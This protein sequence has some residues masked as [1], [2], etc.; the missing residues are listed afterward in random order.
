MLKK[1]LFPIFLLSLFTSVSAEETSDLMELSLDDLLN[2][3]V[4]TV[5]KSA[6]KLSDAPGVISVVSRDE[7]ERFGGLTLGD[8]LDR[9]PSLSMT[10]AYFTDRSPVASRGDLTRVTSGHVLLLINGRPV[11]ELQEGGISADV[12]ESFPVEIIERIEVIKGPGSVLYGTNAYSGVINVITEKAEGSNVTVSGL[13]SVEGGYGTSGQVNF[14]RGEL[15][16]LAAGRYLN[17]A[18]AEIDYRRTDAT[19]GL[20]VTD[21]VSMPD[22]GTGGYLGASYKGLTLTTTLNEWENQYFI[23][24]NLGQNTWSKNFNNLGYGL[25]VREGWEMDMNLTYTQ[26]RLESSGYP[27]IKRNSRDVLL[28]WTNYVTL[29]EKSKLVF[30]GLYNDVHGRERYFGAVP[31]GGAVQTIADEGRA[32]YAVY[33]QMDYR[34]RENLKLIGGFQ[35]NKA[36][37]IDLDIV[38]R[39]GAIWYPVPRVNVKALYSQAFRAPSINEIGLNHPALKGNS[40]LQPEK[41]A[42]IDFG[43]NYL[44]DRIQGGVNY[45]R[46]EHTASIIADRTIVPG[47]YRNL[48]EV[49]FQGIEFEAKYYVS[50][51]LFLTGSSLYQTNEDRNGLK[52]VTPIANFGAK[53]GISYIWANGLTLSLFD[54]YQ[55]NLD[56][57]YDTQLNPNPG[58]FNLV[59]FFAKLHLNEAFGWNSV[60]QVHAFV[61]VDNLFGKEIWLPDWGGIAGESIPY[62]PGREIHFGLSTSLR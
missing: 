39:A 58:A 49:T 43:V 16:V 22:V 38:P 5:S 7:L 9:V 50:K 59:N 23:R 61:H 24:G 27:F 44:G 40:D 32:N 56:D 42:A 52:N 13:T 30:G 47:L 20:V 12:H 53:A 41:V 1:Y 60:Q 26:V 2:M 57:R 54:I 10:T 33:S 62:I 14:K 28:E 36:G 55:G 35:A 31:A 48:G 25:K 6:E 8:I 21:K 37:N 19:S 45:F 51:H 29:S 11:R 17:R 34:V 4:T 46:S 15:S 18:E 3:E